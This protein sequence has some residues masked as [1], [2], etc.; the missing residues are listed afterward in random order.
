MVELLR[1]GAAGTSGTVT[2]PYALQFKFPKPHLFAYYA[3][4]LTLAESFYLAV[5][6]PYQLLMVGD[7]L[8]RPYGF[9]FASKFE[10]ATTT[11]DERGLS[12]GFSYTD[13]I[14][15]AKQSIMRLDVYLDGLKI[16]SAKPVDDLRANQVK[17]AHGWHTLD[18]V[19]TSTHPLQ[20]PTRRATS[21]VVGPVETLP[22]LS[23]TS[24]DQQP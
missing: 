20:Y 12:L 22:K 21:L 7:P 23:L 13:G 14:E 1:G 3:A 9:E 19:A 24:E 18:V 11:F 4:G 16:L 10:I 6:S 15:A 17:L 2:E 8:C 5:D